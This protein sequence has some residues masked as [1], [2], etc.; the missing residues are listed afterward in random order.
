M[1]KAGKIYLWVCLALLLICLLLDILFYVPIDWYCFVVLGEDFS[2]FMGLLFGI[3]ASIH[4]NVFWGVQ[5]GAGRIFGTLLVL[6]YSYG[7]IY[8]LFA[9]IGWIIE[10]VRIV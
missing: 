5:S 7:I 8:A 2:F 10:H 1:S 6:A 4:F 3:L 9:G